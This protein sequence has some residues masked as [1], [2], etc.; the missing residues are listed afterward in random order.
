MSGGISLLSILIIGVSVLGALT[1]ITQGKIYNWITLPTMVIGLALALWSGGW[2]SIGSSFLGILVGL[3]AY[4]WMF[5]IGVMGAGDVKF[6]MALGALGGFRFGLEVA[7]LGVLLG[8]AMAVLVLL[9]R[10]RLADFTRR[11][12]RFLM[13][14]FVKELELE[15]PKVD[16]KLTMPYGLPIAIAAIWNTLGNPFATLGVRLW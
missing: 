8:G 12:Y 3:F 16:R 2:S 5:A 10:G 6:L 14:V 7:L 1:D 15:F 11:I 13:S 9:G 4:G